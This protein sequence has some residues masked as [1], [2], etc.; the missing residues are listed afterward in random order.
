MNFKPLKWTKE[1]F[2]FYYVGNN[3]NKFSYFNSKI[4][5]EKLDKLLDN[6][7]ILCYNFTQLEEKWN[8]LLSQR[9]TFEYLIEKEKE[10]IYSEINKA[11]DVLNFLEWYLDKSGNCYINIDKEILNFSL[12]DDTIIFVEDLNGNIIG[13]LMPDGTLAPYDSEIYGTP[14][15]NLNSIVVKSNNSSGSV[16][17]PNFCS[18]E[19]TLEKEEYDFC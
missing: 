9:I 3:T 8:W 14:E 13:V 5:N 10:I 6:D 11:I 16:T 1:N 4:Y 7:K 2:D 17:E 12:D 18:S 15:T 19:V